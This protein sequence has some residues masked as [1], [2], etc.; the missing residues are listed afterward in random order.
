MLLGVVNTLNIVDVNPAVSILVELLVSLHDNIYAVLVHRTT[1]AA[2]E[3]IEVDEAGVVGVEVGEELLHLAFSEAEHV[4]T[5]CLGELI[6]VKGAGVVVV[7]DLELALEADES[8]GTA[9]NQLLAHGLS[10]LIRAAHAGASA[11]S[12]AAHGLSIK[13]G[14]ELLVVETTGA[15]LVIDV[16]QGLE[17]LKKAR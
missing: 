11:H 7:H 1:D 16:E 15:V 8:T 17:I 13:G 5:A 6:L 2:D 4:V 3:F 12:T 10:E 9:G 14:G